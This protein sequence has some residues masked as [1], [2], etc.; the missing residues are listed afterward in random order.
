MTP[1]EQLRQVILRSSP[2]KPGLVAGYIYHP[3]GR[4]TLHK[5]GTQGEQQLSVGCCW[6]LV[7]T[8]VPVMGRVHAADPGA[9]LPAPVKMALRRL[10]LSLLTL[11]AGL[12][13]KAAT[14]A[15]PGRPRATRCTCLSGH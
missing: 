8:Q 2:F 14:P 4:H 5:D 1:P 13:R 3:W 11:R 7:D 9:L 6:V 12:P 10:L 15:I